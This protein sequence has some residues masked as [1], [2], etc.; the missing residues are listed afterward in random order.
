MNLKIYASKRLRM[1]DRTS[2]NK[3]CRC[4]SEKL[5][6]PTRGMTSQGQADTD[7]AIVLTNSAAYRSDKLSI[8][9]DKEKSGWNGSIEKHEYFRIFTS[10]KSSFPILT[11]LL[12]E[13]RPF[14]FQYTQTANI[15]IFYRI[16]ISIIS[17][18]RNSLAFP[19]FVF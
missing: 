18:P 8:R 14:T 1:I 19:D 13:R 11:F 9:I 16:S 5:R 2:G 4:L 7:T 6:L 3:N 12:I 17:L 15:D 10:L